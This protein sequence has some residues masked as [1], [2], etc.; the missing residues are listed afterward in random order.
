MKKNIGTSDRVIRI[1]LAVGIGYFAYST[2]FDTQWIKTVLYIVSAV[3]FITL[4]T[5]FCGI[6]K[7]FGINTCKL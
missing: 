1:I 5:G 3:L 4:I 7:L 2:E 6:Y